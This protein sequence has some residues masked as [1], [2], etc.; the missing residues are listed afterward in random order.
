MTTKAIAVAIAVLTLAL[1]TTVSAYQA[2][3][4]PDVYYKDLFEYVAPPTVKVPPVPVEPKLPDVSDPA[5]FGIIEEVADTVALF[6]DPATNIC[7][8]GTGAH[9]CAQ[10]ALSSAQ[11]EDE[12]DA[13]CAAK[14]A[15]CKSNNRWLVEAKLLEAVEHFTV[16]WMIGCDSVALAHCYTSN[17]DTG[18]AQACSTVEVRGDGKVYCAFTVEVGTELMPEEYEAKCVDPVDPTNFV[19]AVYLKADKVTNDVVSA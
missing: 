19:E 14:V 9:A 11:Q 10:Q 16:K 4:V 8:S 6:C 18:Y 15:K 1:P 13:K 3:K 17:W 7:A 12:L 5:V 2:P